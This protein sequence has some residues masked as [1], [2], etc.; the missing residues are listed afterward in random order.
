MCCTAFVVWAVRQ[1]MQHVYMGYPNC[2]NGLTCMPAQDVVAI[3][4]AQCL[5]LSQGSHAGFLQHNT[6]YK[7]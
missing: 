1:L 7:H 3:A 5:Q 2:R 6:P 4:S